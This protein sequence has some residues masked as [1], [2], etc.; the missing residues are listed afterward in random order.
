MELE[1]IKQIANRIQRELKNVA[2]TSSSTF[3]ID[4][5]ELTK[6]IINAQ[7]NTKA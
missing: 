2:Y 7:D 6:R 1:E 4:V 3:L 5:E